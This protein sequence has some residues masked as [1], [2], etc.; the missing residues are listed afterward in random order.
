[1]RCSK[2]GSLED[3]VI[4]SR[5]SKDGTL[6]RRRRECGSCMARFTTYERVEES[7]PLVVKK[8][9]ER[10][11]FSR[12]KLMSGILKACEKRP[13][14]YEEVVSLVNRV[15]GRVLTLGEK[16]VS[17]KIVGEE[18]MEELRKLD[19]VAY[20]RFASVYRQFRDLNHF[21]EEIKLMYDK[22]GKKGKDPSLE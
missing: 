3:R 22:P 13:I 14:K 10:E 11:P 2:C 18:V 8:N 5:T 7:I 12:H 20:V 19:D 6:I 21:L 15:E 17:S 16:E 4:D 9:G 1:M